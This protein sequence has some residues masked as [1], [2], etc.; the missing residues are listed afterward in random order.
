MDHTDPSFIEER[1]LQLDGFLGKL[2]GVPHVCSM[3]PVQIFL[4]LYEQIKEHSVVFRE[5]DPGLSLE[6]VTSQGEQNM[7]V[8]ARAEVGGQTAR[9]LDEGGV[10]DCWLAVRR[11]ARA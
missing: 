2:L 1:R 6:L 4:G 11:G 5:Q 9:A 3:V 8:A 7:V 10:Q